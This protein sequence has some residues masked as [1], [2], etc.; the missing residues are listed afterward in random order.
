LPNGNPGDSLTGLKWVGS[1]NIE[2]EPLRVVEWKR[3]SGLLGAASD[4]QSLPLEEFKIWESQKLIGS[5]EVLAS[6][7][8]GYPWMGQKSLGKGVLVVMTSLPNRKASNLYHGH[9]LIPL[10]QRLIQ[11]GAKRL[12]KVI[13]KESGYVANSANL[14][15]LSLHNDAI[16]QGLRSGVFADKNKRTVFNSPIEEVDNQFLDVKEVSSLFSGLSFNH[17]KDLSYE[18]VNLQIEISKYVFLLALILLIVEG[19]LSLGPR[20]SLKRGDQ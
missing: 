14:T 8:D 20:T 5:Y 4:G 7:N 19:I 10:L 9:L 16:F 1:S 3:D 11:N 13:F 17:L 12:G 18:E 2:Q 6:T 15:P